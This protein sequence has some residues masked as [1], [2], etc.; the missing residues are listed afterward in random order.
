MPALLLLSVACGGTVS[1]CSSNGELSQAEAAESKD[2][3]DQAKP[4]DPGQDGV[5]EGA[6]PADEPEKGEQ[7]S[8]KLAAPAPPKILMDKTPQELAKD[9]P[10]FKVFLKRNR[11]IKGT[12]SI[13][14]TL[15]GRLLNGEALPHV[16]EH[17]EIIPECRERKTNYGTSE[18]IRLINDSAAKVA[19]EAPGPKL[20]V[21]NMSKEGGGNISWSRSHNAGRD[22]DIAFYMLDN[23]SGEPVSA[24]ALLRF[25]RSLFNLVGPE[26]EPEYRFDVERNWL[27]VKHLLTHPVVQVQ[28]IFV[29]KPLKRAMLKHGKAAGASAELLERAEQILWQPSDSAKHHDHFHIRVVCTGEDRAEGCLDDGPM[30]PWFT[31]TDPMPMA[32]RAAALVPGLRDPDAEMRKS[33][34][35]YVVRIKAY[36][37]SP[38]LFEMTVFDPSYELRIEA[39]NTL[40]EWRTRDASTVTSFERWLRPPGEGILVDDPDYSMDADKVPLRF[41]LLHQPY[42]MG[43]GKPRTA[44]FIKRA[45]KTLTKMAAPD[46]AP[47]LADALKSKR[48][49]GDP[50]DKGMLEARL[51]ARAAIHVMDKRLVPALLD[52]LLHESHHV[53]IS[54]A[55]AL[56]RI[57]NHAIRGGWG[58]TV[59][60]ETME[61]NAGL[62][63]DWWAEHKDKTRDELVIMG[64][65]EHGARVFDLD[66][67]VY[68]ERLVPLTKRNDQLGYNADRT[69][70]RMT[71]RFTPRDAKAEDKHKRWIK[72]YPED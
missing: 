39:L 67:K 54:S 50:G 21:C 72:W 6:G 62:W 25:G 32:I 30:W 71:G 19:K 3:A 13:G 7:A 8:E 1:G 22:V 42:V 66:D 24:P 38:G 20:M 60:R 47:Y 59:S 44:V 12:A 53:R 40:A 58:P 45:F 10:D 41:D 2:I 68:A 55:R 37:T 57:T 35:D 11:P 49:I 51:A 52:A 48:V 16:G 14:T 64:F 28:W 5:K 65:R 27:L 61:K 31:D 43:E 4:A 36:D 70:V 33:I 15:K 63:R 29:Y 9:Q 17:Y 26:E 46:A 56:S 23:K 69:L 18:L 34:Y